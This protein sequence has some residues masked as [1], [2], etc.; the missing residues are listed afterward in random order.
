MSWVWLDPVD[1]FIGSLPFRQELALILVQD[2]DQD[3]FPRVEGAQ[4]GSP[5]VNTGLG[6][7]GSF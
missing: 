2:E 5:V 7:L 6:L 1:D 4:L 3:L